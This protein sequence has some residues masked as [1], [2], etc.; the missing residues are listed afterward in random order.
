[1]APITVLTN[2]SSMLTRSTH[3]AFLI[4]IIPPSSLGS[5]LMNMA[6]KRPKTTA[7]RMKRTKSQPKRMA[8]VNELMSRGKNP[9]IRAV[10]PLSVATATVYPC[11]EHTNKSQHTISSP[12]RENIDIP[13]I[14]SVDVPIVRQHISRPCL[15]CSNL[16]RRDQSRWRQRP[17]D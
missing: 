17:V 14:R 4:R 5:S 2:Q 6:P 9:K 11:Q 8:E 15:N 12:S 16:V 13:R 10:T 3:T 7:H 1:M